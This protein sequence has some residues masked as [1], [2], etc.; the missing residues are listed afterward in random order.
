MLFALPRFRVVKI[1]HLSEFSGIKTCQGNNSVNIQCPQREPESPS[2]TY[3]TE[4]RQPKIGLLSGGE[5]RESVVAA[6]APTKSGP[7]GMIRYNLGSKMIAPY[8]H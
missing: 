1:I 2:L 6:V 4:P 3:E 5:R 8:F 7:R